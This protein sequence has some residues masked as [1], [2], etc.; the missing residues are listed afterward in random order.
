MQR[1]DNLE[2]LE[3]WYQRQC[4]GEWEHRL[5]MQLQTLEDPGW[6]LTIN[7]SGTSAANARPQRLSFDTPCG[8][9]IDCSIGGE[10]FEG[11]GDPRKLE[12]IIGVFRHWVDISR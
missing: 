3:A 4:N 7:L 8:D 10:R 5:G 9:W 6:H 11:Q 2:W 12:Q 1:M